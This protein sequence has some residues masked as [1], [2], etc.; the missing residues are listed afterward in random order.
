MLDRLT[1]DRLAVFALDAS[2]LICFSNRM[3]QYNILDFKRPYGEACRTVEG[4]HA[5]RIRPLDVS[6]HLTERKQNEKRTQ[7]SPRGSG[8]H[9]EIE[10]SPVTGMRIVAEHDASPSPVMGL[11]MGPG[12]GCSARVAAP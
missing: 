10:V 9:P 8:R 4:I 3:R 6:V 2:P 5:E 7:G 12:C 1:P 11:V